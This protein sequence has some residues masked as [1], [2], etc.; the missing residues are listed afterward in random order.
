ML[1]AITGIDPVNE[2]YLAAPDLGSNAIQPL[3]N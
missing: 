3:V 2:G 1:K